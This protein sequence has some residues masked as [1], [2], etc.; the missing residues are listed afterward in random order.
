[1]TNVE[2]LNKAF[3]AENT[4]DWGAL[5]GYLHPEVM[6][7]VHGESAHSAIAGREDFIDQIITDYKD[8]TITFT[9]EGMDVSRSGNRVAAVLKYS[10]NTRC[11]KVIDFE[12]SNIRWVH[13]FLMDE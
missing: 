7:F 12:D 13:E 3:E 9:C 10:N 8:S 1:M 6:W 5:G 11:M 4:R 2:L